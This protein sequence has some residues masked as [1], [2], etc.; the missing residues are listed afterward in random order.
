MSGRFL[1]DW[2]TL[3][4]SLFNTILLLWLGLT[5]LLNAERRSWGIWLA[6]IGLLAG[7]LF[8]VSH[9]TLLT[10]DPLI[11]SRSIEFWWRA[12]WVPLI[13]LP[14]AWYT[15]VLWYTGFWSSPADAGEVRVRRKLQAGWGIATAVTVAVVVLLLLS[16][17]LPTYGQLIHFDLAATPTVGRMPLLIAGYPLY[18]LLCVGLALRTLAHPAPS[19]RIMGDLA[20]HRARPW[21]VTTSIALLVAS[22]LVAITMGWI[23]LQ[24]GRHPVTHASLTGGIIW[25]D[26]AIASCLAV[27]IVLLGQA[28]IS[29]EIFTGHN[30]P[31]RGFFRY[32]RRAVILAG[33]YS[34]IVGWSLTARLRPVYSLVL[35]IMVMTTFYAL[36]VWRTFGGRERALAQLH[37]FVTSQGLYSE[38]LKGDISSELEASTIFQALCEEVL[39]TSL[40]WLAPCGMSAPLVASP[41]VYP[42]ELKTPLPSLQTLTDSLSDTSMSYVPLSPEQYRG[43][44]GAVPLRHERGLM[45]V[46]LLGEKSDGGLYSQEEIEIAQ[47]SG[48]RLIDLQCSAEMARRLMALQRQKLAETQI[49][50]QRTRRTLHD[51]VLPRLH[52]ALLMLQGSLVS[53]PAEAADLLAETHRQVADLLHAMPT[54][55]VPK[56][57][58][59]G[60]VEVLRRTVDSELM[61]SFD[62]VQWD[63]SQDA[64]VQLLGMPSLHTEVLFYAVR[65]AIR[66]AAHHG[67]QIRVERGL[68]LTVEFGVG[69]QL[70]KG[71]VVRIIDNGPGI[72][73]VEGGAESGGQGLAL[74]TTMMAIIGGTLEIESAPDTGTCIT[75]RMPA[76][77]LEAWA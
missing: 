26:L 63:V 47:A 55:V 53:V 41:L 77:S 13:A 74:H 58:R 25:F 32:W 5:V 65:E 24:L 18:A 71:L 57:A 59:K 11:L 46:L 48:E 23:A 52:A 10:H 66:N 35:T 16:G 64:E 33:G 37:P 69:G 22:L 51:E 7:A 3:A 30:L 39:G 20:R 73:P 4:V 21:F 29:Y 68:T 34:V 27:A 50:D 6:G 12:G 45:G 40:A 9:S 44:V 8:F 56:V 70:Q 61:G 54:S 42:A 19:P 28:I 67:Q 17:W 43:A 1:L 14:Y 62:R 49:V 76:S 60:V 38:L 31:R 15:L 75:L 72:R 2:A 36:L